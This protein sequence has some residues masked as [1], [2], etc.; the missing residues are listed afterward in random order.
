MLLI[1]RLRGLR[2]KKLTHSRKRRIWLNPRSTSKRS[3]SVRN[4]Q[5]YTR[6]NGE[7]NISLQSESVQRRSV[8]LFCFFRERFLAFRNVIMYLLIPISLYKSFASS[9]MFPSEQKIV[10]LFRGRSENRMSDRNG[11]ASVVRFCYTTFDRTSPALMNI[12][13]VAKKLGGSLHPLLCDSWPSLWVLH[14][15]CEACANH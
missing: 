5:R 15:I 9:E 7:G 11:K 12:K 13:G 2:P 14:G 8:G 1:R 3:L 10:S 6:T 4:W